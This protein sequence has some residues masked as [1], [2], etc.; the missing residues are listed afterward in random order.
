LG[1]NNLSAFSRAFKNKNGQSPELW[2]KQL[3]LN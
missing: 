2:R 3:L 1:Y